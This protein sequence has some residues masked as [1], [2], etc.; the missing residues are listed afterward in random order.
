MV[1]QPY[2]GNFLYRQQEIEQP[3]DSKLKTK[4]KHYGNMYNWYSYE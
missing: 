1:Q 4:R 2:Y 3:Y